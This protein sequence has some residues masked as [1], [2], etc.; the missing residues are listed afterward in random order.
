MSVL[1]C[2]GFISKEERFSQPATTTIKT[3]K[4]TK[5]GKCPLQ[6]HIQ[7]EDLEK[8]VKQLAQI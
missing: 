2:G 4:K 7:P 5:K 3:T 1:P 8:Y 6:E